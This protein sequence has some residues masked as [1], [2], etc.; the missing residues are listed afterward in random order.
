MTQKILILSAIIY[1]IIFFT[2]DIHAQSIDFG[3]QRIGDTENYVSSATCGPSA[4]FVIKKNKLNLIHRCKEEA[5]KING[6][7]VVYVEIE[8]GKGMDCEAGCTYK[9]AASI[10][11]GNKESKI[12]AKPDR[13]IGINL[14]IGEQFRCWLE[15]S[16]AKNMTLLIDKGEYKWKIPYNEKRTD[17]FGNQ[18]V[19]K[20][21]ALVGRIN[22]YAHISVS[23][24]IL[25]KDCKGNDKC[26]S[27]VAEAKLDIALCSTVKEQTYRNGCY[28]GIAVRRFDK[29]LCDKL[30]YGSQIDDF[31]KK[32]CLNNISRFQPGK[33]KK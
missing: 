15:Q 29:S 12:T 26:V 6:K 21:Y 31:Q 18:C 19:V 23:F 10:I 7:K 20:G 14:E 3:T 28:L 17:E 16:S 2:N 33:K 27:A 30:V 13:P 24:P 22:D 8:H 32:R 4:R 1:S 11:S 9:K 5:F 25:A